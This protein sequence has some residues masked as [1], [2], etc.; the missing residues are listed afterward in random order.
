MTV[1]GAGQSPALGIARAPRR[2]VCARACE[3]SRLTTV[4]CRIAARQSRIASRTHSRVRVGAI[5]PG[6]Q[7][8]Q[9][10]YASPLP[11][12]GRGRGAAAAAHPL[13]AALDRPRLLAGGVLGA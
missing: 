13:V 5:A 8:L 9:Y 12:R 2:R 4:A 11:P 6:W 1:D 10:A 7:R 3:T